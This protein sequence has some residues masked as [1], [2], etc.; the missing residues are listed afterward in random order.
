[1]QDVVLCFTLRHDGEDVLEVVQGR[2]DG[3]LVAGVRGD[4]SRRTE[5][6]RKR[7]GGNEVALLIPGEARTTALGALE[8]HVLL[9]QHHR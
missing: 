5:A 6:V 1:M 9:Q 4:V 3:R 8:L 7:A 2:R